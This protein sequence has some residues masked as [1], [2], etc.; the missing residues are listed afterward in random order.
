ML[1]EFNQ[2]TYHSIA[3]EELYQKSFES[4]S[5]RV[6]IRSLTNKLTKPLCDSTNEGSIKSK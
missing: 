6:N 1:T 2:V 3:L 5:I 4:K